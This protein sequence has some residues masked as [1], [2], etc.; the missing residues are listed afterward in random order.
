[1]PHCHIKIYFNFLDV[2]KNGLKKQ[3]KQKIFAEGL[4]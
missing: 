2:Q 3:K 4:A 1:M